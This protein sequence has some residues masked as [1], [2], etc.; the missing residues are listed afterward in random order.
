VL[1]KLWHIFIV[2]HKWEII[3]TH[4]RKPLLFESIDKVRM[5]SEEFYIMTTGS[6]V[7][8]YKCQCGCTKHDKVP[9]IRE[10]RIA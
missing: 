7:Y 4:V 8:Y 1:L 9:G 2:G 5:E 3:A 10:E 6:T